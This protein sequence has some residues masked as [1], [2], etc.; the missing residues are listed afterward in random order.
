MSNYID[1][2]IAEFRERFNI[3]TVFHS[4][5]FED[6]RHI[7]KPYY[8][9]AGVVDAFESFLTQKLKEQEAMYEEAIDQ[10]L[11]DE[12]LPMDGSSSAEAEFWVMDMSEKIRQAVKKAKGEV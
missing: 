5:N 7:S 11:L 8:N 2:I 6:A 3:E 12:T 10:T 9:N 1:S 4:D